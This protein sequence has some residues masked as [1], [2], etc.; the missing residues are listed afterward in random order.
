MMRMIVRD[1][2]DGLD[3]SEKGCCMGWVQSCVD[4][5]SKYDK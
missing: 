3:V 1:D 4:F 2:E 5:G